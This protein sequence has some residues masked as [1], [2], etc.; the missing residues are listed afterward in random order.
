MLRATVASI[1]IRYLNRRNLPYRVFITDLTVVD[2]RFFVHAFY[3]EETVGLSAFLLIYC[4]YQIICY[5]MNVSMRSQIRLR[6]VHGNVGGIV[7][8]DMDTQK[9]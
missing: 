1:L 5:N 4:I 2:T 3:C 9:I 7:L 8:L 6:L